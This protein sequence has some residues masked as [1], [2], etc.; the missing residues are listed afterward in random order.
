MSPLTFLLSLF[1]AS[2]AA[3]F[4]GDRRPGRRHRHRAG[5][6]RTLQAMR[7]SLPRVF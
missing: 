2:F 7:R 4:L 3:G 5:L 6:S 1:A